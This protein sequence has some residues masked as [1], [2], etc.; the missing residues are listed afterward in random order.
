M[1]LQQV[2]KPPEAPDEQIVRHLSKWG[3]AKDL[4]KERETDSTLDSCMHK[5]DPKSEEATDLTRKCLL[6]SLRPRTFQLRICNME[7]D[8][9]PK[10]EPTE[11][12]TLKG[13]P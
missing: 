7:T 6:R 12:E 1:E 2:I 3:P 8:K 4:R 5:T 9:T 11:T 10:Q 13:A